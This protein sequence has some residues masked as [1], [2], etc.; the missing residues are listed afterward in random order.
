MLMDLK[1]LKPCDVLI[2]TGRFC[3]SYKKE[4]IVTAVTETRVLAEDVRGSEMLYSS[5]QLSDY[6]KQENQNVE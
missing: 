6:I 3:L 5:E 2:Y 4:L 1:T